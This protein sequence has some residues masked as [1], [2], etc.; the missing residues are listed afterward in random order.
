MEDKKQLT[1][2]EKLKQN[3]ALIGAALFILGNL[4]GTSIPAELISP[5]SGWIAGIL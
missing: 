2:K 5:L 3:P 4:T 1:T